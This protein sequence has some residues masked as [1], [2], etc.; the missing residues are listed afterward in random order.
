MSPPGNG[1]TP[2][3]NAKQLH[4]HRGGRVVTITAN[5]LRRADNVH[6]SNVDNVLRRPVT[7]APQSI[8]V[9]TSHYVNK[10]GTPVN[11]HAWLATKHKAGS[12][13]VVFKA[14]FAGQTEQQLKAAMADALFTVQGKPI[15]QGANIMIKVAFDFE[16][17]DFDKPISVNEV[18]GDFARDCIRESVY[19]KLLDTSRCVA[20]A[21]LSNTCA[22]ELVP[23]FYWSGMVR[24]STTGRRAYL[25]VMSVAP[26]VILQDHL[27][28]HVVTAKVYVAV[29]R[30]VALLWV[31]GITHSD[32]HDKNQLYD[33]HGGQVTIVDFGS[34]VPLPAALR[35][36]VRATLA[37]AIRAN[38]KSLAALWDDPG[39][40]PFGLGIQ[41]LTNAVVAKRYGKTANQLKSFWY[42]PDS[43]TLK[44]LYNEMSPSERAKVPR[45]RH[46]AWGVRE[47]PSPPPVSTPSVNRRRLLA[48]A[49]ASP[50]PR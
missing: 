21:G 49:I 5:N 27:R 46:Q 1:T 12:F 16:D 9:T 33:A 29:E 4:S 17:S 18:Q 2:F 8:P 45:L 41:R 25:T 44:Q 28:T 7:R 31:H 40:S 24:D 36:G 14:K 13:G 6:V 3:A 47:S 34:V 38:V 37:K 22:R 26:G 10:R 23:D 20:V 43:Q 11:Y 15:P 32:F 48:A 50:L 19:H 39:T 42:N 35:D 30:A